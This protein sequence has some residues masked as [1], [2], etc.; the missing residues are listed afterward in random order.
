MLRSRFDSVPRAF[1]KTLVP[2]D[3]MKQHQ[4]VLHLFIGILL[5]S[6]DTLEFL[7]HMCNLFYLLVWH[8]VFKSFL[9]SN[10][11]PIIIYWHL[12]IIAKWKLLYQDNAMESRNIAK[13]SQVW[14]E[15]IL[16]LRNEDLISNWLVL[17]LWDITS[18]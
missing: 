15:F 11:L 1:N 9:L 2:K 7:Y 8:L 10:M 17:S 14:N 18:N 4:Q 3:E 5:I 16:S 12:E 6:F 13:F